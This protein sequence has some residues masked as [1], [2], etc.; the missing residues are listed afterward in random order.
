MTSVTPSILEAMDTFWARWFP[1]TQDWT[2]WIAFLSPMF[3]LPWENSEAQQLYYL[4]TER[5]ASPTERAKQIWAI[6]GRR[7]GKSRIL[8]M[9]AVYL[10]IFG[11]WQPYL[12]PGEVATKEFG[13]SLI[14]ILCERLVQCLWASLI[15][16]HGLIDS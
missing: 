13:L 5:K 4:L 8:S 11:D 6:I 3:A 14:R 2:A 12:A 9:V 16:R 1:R 10:A 7:G 15:S